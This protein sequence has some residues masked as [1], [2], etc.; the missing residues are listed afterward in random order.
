MR[1]NKPESEKTAADKEFEARAVS[2]EMDNIERALT[3]L[4]RERPG[5]LSTRRTY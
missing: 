1:V 2:I 3:G 5:P 4:T